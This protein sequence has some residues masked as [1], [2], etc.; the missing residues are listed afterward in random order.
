MDSKKSKI[1]AFCEASFGSFV[2]AVL[3]MALIA[4]VI[5]S[6]GVCAG[7]KIA[8]NEDEYNVY[9]DEYPEYISD[10]VYAKFTTSVSDV[11][12]YKFAFLSDDAMDPFADALKKKNISYKEDYY[13]AFNISLLQETDD[14]DKEVYKSATIYMPLPDDA[15]EYPDYCTFYK[16]SGGTASVVPTKIYTDED[17]IN[18]VQIILSGKADYTPIYGFVFEDPAEL[19]EEEEEEEDDEEEEDE[20]EDE[21]EE[22]VTKAPTKAPTKASTPTPTKASSGSSKSEPTKSSSKDSGK[23]STPARKDNSP[24]TGDE[25]DFLTLG[26][27]GAGAFSVLSASVILQIRSRKKKKD[28]KSQEEN[29]DR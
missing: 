18:Y 14:D 25:M 12:S 21:D 11:D 19:E 6:A 1:R 4:T 9:T 28:T 15:Q 26:I 17:D 5:P 20:E 2:S 7:T 16:V 22:V 23:S 10:N 8:F 3:A 24:K 13:T 27:T 29:N